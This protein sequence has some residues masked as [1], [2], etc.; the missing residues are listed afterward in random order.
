M[1]AV[2]IP[3]IEIPHSPSKNWWS[4]IT[5][6]T[7]NLRDDHRYVY[8]LQCMMLK[9]VCIFAHAGNSNYGWFMQVILPFNFYSSHRLY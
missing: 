4:R 2:Y 9:V 5:A 3:H 1:I 8:I 6:T 7:G